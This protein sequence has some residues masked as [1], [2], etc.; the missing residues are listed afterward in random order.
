MKHNK[1]SNTLAAIAVLFYVMPS[2]QAAEPTYA[3]GV[4][5][6]PANDVVA[7][8]NAFKRAVNGDRIVLEKGVYK[9]SGIT[10]SDPTTSR[11]YHDR[12]GVS[13]T[14]AGGGKA[15]GDVLIDIAGTSAE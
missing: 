8:T 9:F 11:L 7:F 10:S 14:I 3:D 5:T 6:V 13:I 4:W 15:A 1:I 2:A 12:N